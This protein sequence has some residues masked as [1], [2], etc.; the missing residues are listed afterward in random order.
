MCL[1]FLY[2]FSE[3]FLILRRIERDIS[4]NVRYICLHVKCLL[5]CL[6]L[7]TIFIVTDFLELPKYNI[8]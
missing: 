3:R 8:L 6:I 5:F 2:N 1:D 7:M 4:I